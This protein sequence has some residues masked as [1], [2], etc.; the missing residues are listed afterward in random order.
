[1]KGRGKQVIVRLCWKGIASCLRT[2]MQKEWERIAGCSGNRRIPSGRIWHRKDA[3]DV[4]FAKSPGYWDG[5]SCL[6]SHCIFLWRSCENC[7][8]HLFAQEIIS[9]QWYRSHCGATK[10]L[11]PWWWSPMQINGRQRD[12]PPHP[13]TQ[14]SAQLQNQIINSELEY[15]PLETR[16]TLQIK[17]GYLD[18]ANYSVSH[19]P[20]GL[21]CIPWLW[22]QLNVP[23]KLMKGDQQKRHQS[24]VCVE[25]FH[26]SL[27][28]EKNNFSLYGF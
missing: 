13:V 17:A 24:E 28:W 5:T 9:W 10:P 23:W 1:M 25:V 2:H 18:V 26:L 14:S 22:G 16:T 19:G 15:Q 3:C 7:S 20:T 21:K 4:V 11:I 12:S 27:F 6:E 8:R